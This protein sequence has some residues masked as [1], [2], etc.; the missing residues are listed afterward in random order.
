MMLL[1]LALVLVDGSGHLAAE[2]G[3]V[4]GAAEGHEGHDLLDA[5][6][7]AHGGARG[8]GQAAAP[9]HGTIEGQGGVGLGEVVVRAHLH[10]PVA[11]VDHFDLDNRTVAEQFDRALAHDHLAGNHGIGW[12]TVTSLVPPENVAPTCTSGTS[13]GT[14]SI[15]SPRVSTPRPA[16]IRSATVRPSR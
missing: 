6:L 13:S 1:A 15:T 8:D 2:A 14:P 16:S 5:R 12:G 11:G 7:E 9:G 4:A 10:G 3:H